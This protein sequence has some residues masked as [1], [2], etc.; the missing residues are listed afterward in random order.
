MRPLPLS[1]VVVVH[2]MPREA[3]RTLL[4]L[5]A[6]YQRGID[7]T[8]YEV[9]VVENGS[10]R[11]LSREQI[12]GLAG[13][14]RYLQ[15][16]NA[17]AS[18]APAVNLGLRQAAGELVGVMIDGA[19]LAS[20]G[21][22]R[23][24]LDASKVHTHPVVATLGWHLGHRLQ[25]IAVANGYDAA[26][27]DR[28]LAGIDWPQDGYRLFEIATLDESC[29]G[30][31]FRPIMESNALF[32]RRS[33]WEAL[34]GMDERFDLPG[35]GYVNPDTLVRACALPD[36][37]LILLM[38]E[39]TLHQVHGGVSTNAPLSLYDANAREWGE[40]YARI[41]GAPFAR[42]TLSPL[43][44]GRMPPACLPHLVASCGGGAETVSG[45]HQVQLE[46]LLRSRSWR[47]TAPAR[48][49]AGTVRSMKSILRGA[50]R[51]HTAR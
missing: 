45:Y 43:Y 2:D 7:A 32:L 38:G 13:N 20:P 36:A 25:N 4:S 16:Q 12:S 34:G 44:Y 3:P 21:L 40:Q 10:A 6:A 5:S 30:G 35:G 9:V 11:P 19:R 46:R 22:L 17:S 47:W 39:G 41:R 28:L 42:T 49:L 14:F 31:W 8:E 50:A 1:V 26:E 29:A 51:L 37:A 27:E 23:A 15:V 18:P 24:A 48:R 33:A